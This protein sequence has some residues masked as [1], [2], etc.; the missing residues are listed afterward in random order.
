MEMTR[1]RPVTES[2]YQSLKRTLAEKYKYGRG[3]Y[4]H[5]K[6]EFIRRA[7]QLALKK[8]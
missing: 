2:A 8:A 1:L 3:A 7:T 4:T 5:G 6:T